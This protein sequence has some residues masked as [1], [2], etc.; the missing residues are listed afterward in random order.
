MFNSKKVQYRTGEPD[1]L[2]AEILGIGLD[3]QTLGIRA[4]VDDLVRVANVSTLANNNVAVPVNLCGV[5]GEILS[6]GKGETVSDE[7]R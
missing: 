3:F 2:T 4:G 5:H 7:Y 6:K 1:G